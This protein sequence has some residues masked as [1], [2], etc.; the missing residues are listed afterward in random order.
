VNVK[1]K[2]VG[3]GVKTRYA[4]SEALVPPGDQP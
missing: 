3:V 1:R 2:E 4:V